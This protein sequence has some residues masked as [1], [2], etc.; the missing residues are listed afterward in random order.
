M[1][2][3]RSLRLVIFLALLLLPVIVQAQA[4][5]PSPSPVAFSLSENI[6]AL[7]QRAGGLAAIFRQ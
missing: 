4:P 1:N 6:A 5:T 2:F 3:K 7:S